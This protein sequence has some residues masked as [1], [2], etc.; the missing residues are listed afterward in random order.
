[1]RRKKKIPKSV[2]KFQNRPFNRWA[3]YFFGT[4]RRTGMRQ[5]ELASALGVSQSWLSKVESG[6]LEPSVSQFLKVR[7]I[8]RNARTA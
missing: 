3:L 4:R 2:L 8:A 6:M 5:E 7:R 1:M